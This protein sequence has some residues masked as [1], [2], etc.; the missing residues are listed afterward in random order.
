MYKTRY[1]YTQAQLKNGTEALLALKR[2]KEEEEEQH[3]KHRRASEEAREDCAR[4][5]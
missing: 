5:Y 4:P 2:R 1:N 3:K